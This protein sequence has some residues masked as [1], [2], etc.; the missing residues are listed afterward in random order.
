VG[1][2]ADFFTV[3]IFDP[4]LAGVEPAALLGNVVF[5][6]ERRA[7]REVWVGARQLVSNGR[8]AAQG[9]IIGRFVDLQQRVR[10]G[11]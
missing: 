6:L 4:S 7:I 8:H 3:N 10:A 11:A 2:P 1:R 5:G 9:P